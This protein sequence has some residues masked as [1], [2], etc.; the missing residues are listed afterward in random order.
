MCVIPVFSIQI[1]V[2]LFPV[3]E[4]RGESDSVVCEVGFFSDY[5][6]IILSPF[7]V[8][9]EELFSE[10]GGQRRLQSRAWECTYMNAMPTIPS[11]TTTTFFLF[12]IGA[13][14]FDSA[15]APSGA[16]LMAMPGEDVAHDMLRWK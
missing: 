14:S 4:E 1:Q 6:D 13:A 15:L 3:L 5:D 8:E 11:P 10:L 16:R 2:L 9:F 7:G 12:D